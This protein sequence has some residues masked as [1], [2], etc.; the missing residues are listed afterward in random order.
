[1]IGVPQTLYKSH[2]L[3]HHRF[4]SDYRD[5]DGKTRDQ[6]SIYRYS[7]QPD[8]AESIVRYAVLGPL[9]GDARM[10]YKAALNRGEA[11]LLYAEILS[12]GLGFAALIWA[13]PTFA[14]FV[15]LPIWYLGL[16]AAQAENY[17]EHFGAQPGNRRTDSVSCYSRGY[18]WLLQE[19]TLFHQTALPRYPCGRRCLPRGHRRQ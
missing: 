17:L 14:A 2:H 5:K 10:M 8:R 12:L 9:R 15:Y 4:N 3:N 16:V 13:S 7:R 18:N 1:M 11:G 6:S 19:R